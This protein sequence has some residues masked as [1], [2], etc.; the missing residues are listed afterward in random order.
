MFTTSIRPILEFGSDLF[1]REALDDNGNIIAK[2]ALCRRLI[3]FQEEAAT[4]VLKQSRFRPFFFDLLQ[5]QPLQKRWHELF[6]WHDLLNRIDR[7]DRL[8]QI[9]QHFLHQTPG[10]RAT[11]QQQGTVTR[12]RF[13]A[14]YTKGF[15]NW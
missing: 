13:H 12:E 2:E 9:L 10:N 11:R 7:P 4:R 5:W 3:A 14:F 15:Q 6:L 1:V 8:P